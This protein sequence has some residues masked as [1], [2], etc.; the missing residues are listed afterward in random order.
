MDGMTEAEHLEVYARVEELIHLEPAELLPKQYLLDN[1]FSKIGES[2][3]IAR[4]VWV[5]NLESAL[6]AAN[7]GKGVAAIADGLARFH[8]IIGPR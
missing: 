1:D 6:A 8:Q 5:L 7:S 2:T 3:S 4:K